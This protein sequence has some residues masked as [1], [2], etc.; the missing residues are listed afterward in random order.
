MALRTL[1]AFRVGFEFFYCSTD[2]GR[3]PGSPGGRGDLLPSGAHKP[4][5][6]GGFARQIRI[7]P[8]HC[9]AFPFL[10]GPTG[11]VPSGLVLPLWSTGG[12]SPSVPPQ[13]DPGASL[14]GPF[15]VIAPGSVPG[16]PLRASGGKLGRSRADPA[17]SDPLFGSRLL[18]GL[19]TT[20]GVSFIRGLFPLGRHAGSGGRCFNVGCVAAHAA[21]PGRFGASRHQLPLC[22]HAKH[23]PSDLQRSVCDH[24]PGQGGET[25]RG[26]AAARAPK[27]PAALCNGR[28][29][30]FRVSSRAVRSWWK[31]SSPG[32]AWGLSCTRRSWPGITPSCG[33]AFWCSPFR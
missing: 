2:A 28:G 24:R 25:Q 9:A 13:M 27:R 22:G 21:A 33:G 11:P 20:A 19:L 16:M 30:Q 5:G 14:S 1:P 32:R 10:H 6:V 3:S 31:W 26:A 8:A 23:G 15:G 12:T 29:R 7:G 17:F 4:A 18:S